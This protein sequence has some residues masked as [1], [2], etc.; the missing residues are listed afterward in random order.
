MGGEGALSSGGA[1]ALET[2]HRSARTFITVKLWT[3]FAVL[4]IGATAGLAT[5]G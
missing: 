1:S 2:L 5:A 3:F 4:V